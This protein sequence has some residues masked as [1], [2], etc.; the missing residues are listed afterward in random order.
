MTLETTGAQGDDTLKLP[1][2]QGWDDCV[3]GRDYAP[4]DGHKMA[5]Q[6]YLAGWR[7]A[8]WHYRECWAPAVEVAGNGALRADTPEV[9]DGTCN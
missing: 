5:Q 4:G 6:Q 2:W 3:A 8:R 7:S 9:D 1:F